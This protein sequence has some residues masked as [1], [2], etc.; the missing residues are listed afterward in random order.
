MRTILK[1]TRP[2]Q[3]RAL[4]DEDNQQVVDVDET[5]GKVV[6]HNVNLYDKWKQMLEVEGLMTWMLMLMR[7][8]VLLGRNKTPSPPFHQS[9]IGELQDGQ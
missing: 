3:S 1:Q 2:P 7:N 9:W 5:A 4:D 8:Q 6:G